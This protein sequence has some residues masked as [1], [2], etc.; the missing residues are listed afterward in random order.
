M[1]PAAGL[2]YTG[3]SVTIA[4][5]TG[6]RAGVITDILQLTE[7]EKTAGIRYYLT[8]ETVRAQEWKLTG[9]TAGDPSAALEMSEAG[10]VTYIALPGFTDKTDVSVTATNRYAKA[11]ITLK[12]I[13]Q[14]SKD[15]LTGAA[16]ALYSTDQAEASIGLPAATA[17]IGDFTANG[18]GTYRITNVPAENTAGTDYYICLLYTS[19]SPRDTR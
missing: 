9:A 7:A 2:E 4:T 5:G 17:K 19:P 13:D 8:E 15:P 16:F 18:D 14:D 6:E 12:K 10:G 11:D 1:S 3:K